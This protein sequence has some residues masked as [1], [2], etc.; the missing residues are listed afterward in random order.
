MNSHEAF[1]V[2]VD[3]EQKGPYTVRHL[4]HLLN[5]GLIPAETLYWT[6]GLAQ[7]LPITDLIPLRKKPRI[8][9]KLGW[10]ASVLAVIGALAW[11]FGP[12]LAD[13]WRE[14]TQREYTA[15]G[16][17]WSARGAV[18]SSGI[19]SGKVVQFAPESAAQVTLVPPASADVLVRGNVIGAGGASKTSWRV[20]L[21]FNSLRCEW[22]PGDV[23]MVSE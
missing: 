6:E 13:G 1:Y 12:T 22:L 9:K 8:W 21:S 3:G 15:T 17:Y 14:N 10:A 2:H 20:R 19:P 23:K 16:A 7:W 18:R 5:S 11:F 4:D